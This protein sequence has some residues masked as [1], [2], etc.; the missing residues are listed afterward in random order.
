MDGVSTTGETSAMAR[1]RHNVYARAPRYVDP[2]EWDRVGALHIQPSVQGSRE[3][4]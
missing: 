2:E 4:P 3:K 1:Y